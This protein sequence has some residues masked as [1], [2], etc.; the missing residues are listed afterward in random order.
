[1]AK[2]DRK[3]LLKEPD[4]FLTIS[5]RAVR[6]AKTHTRLLIVSVSSLLAAVLLVVG[7]QTYLNHRQAQGAQAFAQAFAYY[8]DTVVGQAEPA[9]AAAAARELAQ[10]VEKFGATDAGQQAALALGEVHLRQGQY[11][12]AE[13]VLR[14][15]SEEPGLPAAL[16]PLIWRGLGQA[17]EG[18]KKYAEAAEA[19]QGAVQASGPGP[20]GLSGPG[21]PGPGP[22][23]Q[24]TGPPAPGGPGGGPRIP[25]HPGCGA[26]KKKR[27]GN[28]LAP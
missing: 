27:G 7:I 19:Y 23:R 21:W 17:L 14:D 24:P 1:M 16:A 10:V 20:G 25:A 8:A 26:V 22:H 4:E 11:A 3:K 6:W 9:Q 15:L 5:D 12:E 18:Q 2:I 13:T 28:L